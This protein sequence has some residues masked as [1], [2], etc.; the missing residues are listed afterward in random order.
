MSGLYSVKGARRRG[1]LL[2]KLLLKKHILVFWWKALRP[3]FHNPHPFFV[4]KGKFFL[5]SYFIG[6]GIPLHNVCPG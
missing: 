2:R 5:F 6:T 3:S 1:R 4:S